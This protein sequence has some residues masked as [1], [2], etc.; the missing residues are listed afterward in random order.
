MGFWSNDVLQVY[1]N[2]ILYPIAFDDLGCVYN[3]YM[4]IRKKNYNEIFI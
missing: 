4:Y 3:L 1:I 2:F